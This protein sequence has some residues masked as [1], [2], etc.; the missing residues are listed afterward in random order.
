MAGAESAGEVLTLTFLVKIWEYFSRV[1]YGGRCCAMASYGKPTI[2]NGVPNFLPIN[3]ALMA[4][5]HGADHV[6]WA[7]F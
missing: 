7:T 6:D 2:Y 4:W 5:E 3:H 1:L